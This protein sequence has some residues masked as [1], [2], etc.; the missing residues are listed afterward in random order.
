MEKDPK[1]RVKILLIVAIVCLLIL[2]I[3]LGILLSIV[4]TDFRE[5]LRKIEYISKNPQIVRVEP[6]SSQSIQDIQGVQGIQGN[7]GPIGLQGVTGAQGPQGPQGEQGIQGIPGQT[8]PQ[9]DRGPRGFPG[10]SQRQIEFDGNGHWRFMGDE[11]WLPLIKEI[12]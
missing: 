2:A 9:G 7:A 12:L 1:D 8:G 6:V 10:M 3:G 4:W 5:G 11:E